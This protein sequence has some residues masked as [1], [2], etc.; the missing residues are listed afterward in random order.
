MVVGTSSSMLGALVLLLLWSSSTTVVHAGPALDQ[1]CGI[2][3]SSYVTPELCVSV[4]CV[5]PSCHSARGAPELAALETRLA[6]ANATATK[7]SIESALAHAA[8][9]Q[10]RKAMRSCVQLYDGTVPALQ[11]AARSVSKGRYSGAREVLQAAFYVPSGCSGMAGAV[12]LPRE[13]DG[14]SI[15]ALVVHAVL[16]SMRT[17]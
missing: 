15:L 12:A 10:T 1:L 6:V 5:D 9:A 17:P 7:A 14:F 2:L 8:D 11:W 13:N 16:G 3:G 4:L